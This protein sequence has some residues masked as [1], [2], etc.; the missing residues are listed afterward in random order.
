MSIKLRTRPTSD[1]RQSLYLD[2]YHQGKRSHEW[3]Q[4]YLTGDKQRDRQMLEIANKVKA[5][6]ELA[7]AAHQ[8]DFAPLKK[9]PLFM[10]VASRLI[11][12]K[13]QSNQMIYRKFLIHFNK[14]GRPNI[15][16]NEITP[17]FC[18]GFQHH[19]LTNCK[20]KPISAWLYFSKLRSIL[21]EAMNQGI[22]NR[23]PSAGIRFVIQEHGPKYLTLNELKA[24][25]LTP[26]RYPTVKDAFLFSSMTG[27][28]FSDILNLKWTE[29]VENHLEI[30]QQKTLRM[31][32]VPL[33]PVAQRILKASEEHADG[34][35]VFALPPY[36]TIQRTLRQWAK[37]A[38]IQ[39]LVTFHWAR[40]SF[41]TLALNS[42][43]DIYTVSKLLGHKKLATTQVYAQLIDRTKEEA[44]AKLPAI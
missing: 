8:Y 30:V 32:M 33:N 25:S 6:R 3:L 15:P 42:G 36:Q 41:A 28:R 9:V 5:E 40:H 27:L 21:K 12:S 14:F 20:L 31:V 34:L 43:V 1:G 4:L 44:I 26:C 38:G 37:D 19:L 13:G 7:V 11:E 17:D 24:L 2:I 23:D 35:R 29:V 39:K 16:F 18:K 10:E 22:I